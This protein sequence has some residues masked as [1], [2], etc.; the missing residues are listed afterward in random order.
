MA[1]PARKEYLHSKSLPDLLGD[2]ASETQELVRE[3]IRLATV[4]MRQKAVATGK[5]AA[6]LA[7]AG[8]A[9]FLGLAA[10][11]ALAIIAINYGLPLWASALI[12]TVVWFTVAGIMAM[13][14]RDRLKKASPPTPVQTIQ[15]VKEDIQW[16]KNPKKFAEK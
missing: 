13:V 5:A 11:T 15:T 3:E 1:D 16:A 8:I 2:L 4:E 6:L 7:G 10:L 12:V 14:G 9:A